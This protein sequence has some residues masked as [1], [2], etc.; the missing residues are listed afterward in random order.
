MASTLARQTTLFTIISPIFVRRIPGLLDPVSRAC[1][2]WS[3]NGVMNE[4]PFEVVPS[5][6]RQ[7]NCRKGTA[8]W[9]GLLVRLVH[10]DLSFS[11]VDARSSELL[12]QAVLKTLGALRQ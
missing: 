12:E 7:T 10:H 1:N 5:R 2:S 3:L 8:G 11:E 9:E 4:S 6:F